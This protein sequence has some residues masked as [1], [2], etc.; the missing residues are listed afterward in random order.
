MATDSHVVWMADPSS[1]ESCSGLL[2]HPRTMV[3]SLDGTW[4]PEAVG[5]PTGGDPNLGDNDQQVTGDIVAWTEKREYGDSPVGESQSSFIISLRDLRAGRTI[6]V[7]D[8]IGSFS[9]SAIGEGWLAWFRYRDD[10]TMAVQGVELADL[11]GRP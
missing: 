9:G 6:E 8:S 11:L 10:D 1:S 4:K 3:A 7:L 2:E 5:A